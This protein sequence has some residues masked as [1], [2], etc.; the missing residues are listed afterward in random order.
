LDGLRDDV[1]EL[2]RFALRNLGNQGVSTTS[3]SMGT[4]EIKVLDQQVK[5]LGGFKGKDSL[6]LHT[7][8][9]FALFTMPWHC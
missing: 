6:V 7:H 1:A 8:S 9:S 4:K 2:V 5:D 3:I